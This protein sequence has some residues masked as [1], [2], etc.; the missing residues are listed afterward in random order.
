[1]SARV[2]GIGGIFFKARDPERLRAW[3]R[4]HL[5]LAP[6]DWGGVV[7][8]GVAASPGGRQAGTVWSV[9]PEDTEYFL[10]STAAFMINYR[11]EELDLVLAALRTEGC[12]VDERIESSEHGR[13]GWV[14]DP[15]GNRVELWEPPRPGGG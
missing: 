14:S 15:E 7:F 9:F 8:D 13:F 1:M 3:Y 4:D 12:V 5:G 2:V 10:P 11:V 6:G